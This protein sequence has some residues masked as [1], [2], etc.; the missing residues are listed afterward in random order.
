MTDLRASL[1]LVL[2]YFD[3]EILSRNLHEGLESFLKEMPT[4]TRHNFEEGWDSIIN[5][6][7]QKYLEN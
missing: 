3:G 2:S 6:S 1:M 7:L 4:S 5:E